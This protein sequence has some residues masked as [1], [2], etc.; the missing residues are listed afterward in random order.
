MNTLIVL[1]LILI[2]VMVCAYQNARWSEVKTDV[3]RI[4]SLKK[5]GSYMLESQILT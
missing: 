4:P 1:A 5:E 2:V 3:Q